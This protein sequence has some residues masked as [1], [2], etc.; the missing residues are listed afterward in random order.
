VIAIVGSRVAVGVISM[1]EV[2]SAV[3]GGS[4]VDVISTV[5]V[6]TVVG[7]GVAV[8]VR[9]AV[10]T[11]VGRAIVGSGCG[12]YNRAAPSVWPEEEI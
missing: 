2:I 10:G 1:V 4:A 7:R 3:G 8:G 9:V 6:I 12:V 11:V 5:G